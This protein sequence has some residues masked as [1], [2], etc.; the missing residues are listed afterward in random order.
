MS[1]SKK[2]Q[3]ASSALRKA[4]SALRPGRGR[5]NHKY[6]SDK[7]KDRFAGKHAPTPWQDLLLIADLRP[8]DSIL[9]MGCAEGDITMEIARH[10]ARA[11]GVEVEAPRVEE[12]TRIAKERG[13]TNI[14]F[15]TGNATDYPLEP[16]S[17]DLV[18]FLGVLGKKNGDG[19]VGLPEL[20]RLLNAARR[21]IYVRVGIQKQ[22]MADRGLTLTAI[23]KLMDERGFDAICFARQDASFGNIIVGS[24]RGTGAKLKKVP[25]MVL[26]PAETVMDHP[27]LRGAE[28]A[29]YNEFT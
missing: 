7:L 2:S 24:R 22:S 8:G 14:A 11:Q 15:A 6:H 10:V 26:V 27:C 1:Q 20:D 21:Q 19:I 23:M 18:F 16:N 12:G 28:I 25:P 9:D 4:L 17:Y 13:L 3:G 29:A 5:K